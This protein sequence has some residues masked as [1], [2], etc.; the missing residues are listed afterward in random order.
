M[1]VMAQVAQELAERRA[2]AAITP[3]QKAARHRRMVKSM[4]AYCKLWSQW[5]NAPTH[6][7]EILARHPNG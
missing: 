2:E 4:R 5:M 3:R 6:F 7:W 1:I